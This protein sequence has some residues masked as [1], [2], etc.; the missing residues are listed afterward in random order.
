[1][2]YTYN[3]GKTSPV[4]VTFKKATATKYQYSLNGKPMGKVNASEFKKLDKYLQ[5]LVNGET[6][7]YN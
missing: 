3:D 6:V 2:I 5:Q 7:T 4:K 1:M